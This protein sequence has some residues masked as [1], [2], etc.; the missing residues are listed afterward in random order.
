MKFKYYILLILIC[1]I[2]FS[3]QADRVTR[4]YKSLVKDKPQKAKELLDK[5]LKKNPENAGAK[6]VYSLYF[7]HPG[8]EAVHL[9]SAYKY[10]LAAGE[11]FANT[12]KSTLKQ[13]NKLG[14]NAEAVA[15]KKLQID[16]LA[17]AQ[18]AENNTVTAYQYFL[19]NYPT[20]TQYTMAVE[21]RNELAFSQAQAAHTHQSY[22]QFLDTYP[23][24]RQSQEA[25]KL[26]DMLLFES[27]TKGG[28]IRAYER[29]IAAYPKSPYRKRAE[30]I[31]FEMYTA[32][33]TLKTY[34]DFVKK[35]PS[36]SFSD[37][38]W[39][40]IYFLYKRDN[41]L[42]NFLK[43]YPDFYNPAYARKLIAAE[44]L[45]YFPV[46]DEEKYG[47]IDAK[48]N[49]QIPITY[50]S[51]ASEYFC[52]G[53][54][55][56]FILVYKDGKITAIDKT[57]K[58]IL[59]YSYNHIEQLEEGLLMVEREGRQ[60]LYHQAGFEILSPNYDLIDLLEDTFLQVTLAGKTGLA[61]LNGRK[62]TPLE[63]DAISS[64][65]ERMLIFRREDKFALL[66]YDKL[67]NGKDTSLHFNY[68]KVEWIKKGY[69]KL[70]TG[71]QQSIITTGQDTVIPSTT[72]IIHALPVGWATET[73]GSFQIYT[74]SGKLLSD[75]V[76]T[77]VKGNNSFYAVKQ[78]D[79][80]AILKKDGTWFGSNN[81]D[82]V[83]LLGNNWFIASQNGVIHVYSQPDKLIKLTDVDK[84]T[85]QMLPQSLDQ[86]WL[87]TEN[88]K[89]K[90]GL[91]AS[92]T[93]FTLSPRYDDIQVWEQDLFKT[94]LKGK[95]GLIN[96][97]GK[98]LIPAVYDGLNY[99]SGQIATLK[100][101]KFGL[102]NLSHSVD[103]VPAYT[104]L[105]KKYDPAGKLFIANKDGVYGLV[106]ASNKPVTEFV[107][108]E[109]RYWQNDVAL[110]MQDDTWY[111]YHISEKRNTFKP[112]EEIEYVK[113]TDDEIVLKVYMDKKY[114]VLSNTKGLL[115]DCEY[116]DLGNVGTSDYP[117]YV[118]EK[119]VKEA[120]V[121]LVFYIDKDGKSIRR[122]IFDNDRYNRIA[123]E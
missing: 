75:S 104:A 77:E 102:V 76:F 66:T 49:L 55:D 54:K 122:Q 32:P 5:E 59:D 92:K 71:D 30:Q 91:Y 83:N 113:Q 61:T 70:I 72:S 48:G 69:I 96:T 28:D 119:N 65:G 20:A 93:E 74:P 78:Q 98:I 80:W 107:F 41:P 79:K 42:E 100:N 7:L 109:I 73:E 8:N 108:D 62:L 31:I 23:D 29:F 67:L 95:T 21:S 88:K 120:G 35:Y 46:Y 112:M 19:D 36:S 47:F 106:T 89:G 6:Y 38:A 39:L 18:A 10:V 123:C 53:V 57:G 99:Q 58:A 56:D 84:Y 87:I 97:Q 110:V 26:Y 16:S 33:H 117:L 114:G 3:T 44:K 12:K 4:A 64:P 45:T 105:L 115:I 50:D 60:G 17:F 37:R 103:I 51:V 13:W 90:K 94:E 14:I 86:F 40:W 27:Q 11:N 121:F 24:A 25:K 15:G 85:F 22:K 116:D 63:Y 1:C 118:G 68:D 52:E 111:L 2:P 9:D 43:V 82:W 101:S 81:Y 34:H